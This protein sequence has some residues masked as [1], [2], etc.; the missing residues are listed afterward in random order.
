MTNDKPVKAKPEKLHVRKVIEEPTIIYEVTRVMG[1]RAP[2]TEVRLK[3]SGDLARLSEELD[4]GR[5][6]NLLLRCRDV[7]AHELND[8]K[9]RLD[10][11]KGED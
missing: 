10:D 3:M 5:V 8:L 1:G 7:F 4:A 11:M 9:K 6:G 2:K